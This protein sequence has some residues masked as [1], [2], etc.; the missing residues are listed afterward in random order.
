MSAPRTVPR[1]VL[2]RAIPIL[3]P[4]LALIVLVL[5][6]RRAR[7]SPAEAAVV[8]PATSVSTAPSTAPS[9]AATTSVS[10][11]AGAADTGAVAAAVPD[12]GGAQDASATKV[13]ADGAVVVD[14]NRA[15]EPDLRKLPGIGPSR[16]RAILELRGRLG[17]FKS[18]D[19]LARIKGIGRSTLKRLRP[20]TYVG[21]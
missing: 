12:G 20:L 13:L 11:A 19:D 3:L 15:T 8:G 10:S 6:G 21:T 9:T 4:V 5:I 18:V 14:L 2:V 17:R 1:A 16:A 7:V